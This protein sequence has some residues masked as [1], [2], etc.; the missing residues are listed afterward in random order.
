MS[1][2]CICCGKKVGLLNGSHLNNQVCD[3]CYFPVGG[4]ITVI[5]E[6]NDLK[7][8]NENREQLINK[9]QTLPYTSIGK[10]YIINYTDLIITKKKNVFEIFMKGVVEGE[11]LVINLFPTWLGL[12]VAIGMLK[13]SGLIDF[14]S[15]KV[16]I[17]LKSFFLYKEI[18]PLIF[19]RPISGSSSTAMGIEIMRNYG[20]DT[21]IGLL[22]SCIMGSTE[23]T[24]YVVALYTSMLG[25]KN[26]KPVLIIGLIADFLCIMFSIL[27]L[28][29]GIL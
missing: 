3:N 7:L 15:E 18:L 23:T 26:I 2:K 6:N 1:E 13:A 24:I 20:V 29:I 4:Y 11:K 25:N 12:F 21:D 9:I 22:T 17:I 14:I 27:A 8:I 19:L 16:Y 10:E 5:E 28:K